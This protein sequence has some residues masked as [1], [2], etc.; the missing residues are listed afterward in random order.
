MTI[1]LLKIAKILSIRNLETKFFCTT[2]PQSLCK[3]KQLF[4]DMIAKTVVL[5]VTAFQP[6]ACEAAI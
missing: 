1:K 5:F 6:I 4:V 3:N 2:L